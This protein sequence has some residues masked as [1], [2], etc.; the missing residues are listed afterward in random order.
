[1]TT[2]CSDGFLLYWK[3]PG[4]NILVTRENVVKIA[5]W[6]LARSYYKEQQRCIIL[7]LNIFKCA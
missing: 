7:D 3:P 2:L 6:G 1:M 5:D 4:A